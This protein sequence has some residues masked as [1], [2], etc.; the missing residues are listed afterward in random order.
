MRLKLL[1]QSLLMMTHSSINLF[2]IKIKA[3]KAMKNKKE[4]CHMASFS[5]FNSLPHL[6][7]LEEEIGQQY[8]KYADE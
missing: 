3:I 7:V 5:M 2:K 8:Q 4:G 6:L 1:L